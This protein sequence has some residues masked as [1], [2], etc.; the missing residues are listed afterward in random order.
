LIS[1]EVQLLSETSFN[2]NTS[3]NALRPSK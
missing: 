2:L 1:L 3:E